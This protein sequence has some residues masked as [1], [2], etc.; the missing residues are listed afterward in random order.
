M[1]RSSS[2]EQR[3]G[4]AGNLVDASQQ[5]DSAPLAEE[6]K[7][8][9]ET[10]G[11]TAY[12]YK[13]KKVEQCLVNLRDLIASIKEAGFIVDIPSLVECI[14][15]R[16]VPSSVISEPGDGLYSDLAQA[17]ERFRSD[18]YLPLSERSRQFLNELVRQPTVK[19]KAQIYEFIDN[20]FDLIR[21][22]HG[23]TLIWKKDSEQY[24]NQLKVVDEEKLGTYLSGKV[25]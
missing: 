15:H 11:V 5:A 14:K 23:E 3:K 20:V 22:L 19:P 18:P 6:V 25:S 7:R 12:E 2:L 8:L 4:P 10:Y 24:Y 21:G 1:N 17:L 9:L 13:V 16:Y